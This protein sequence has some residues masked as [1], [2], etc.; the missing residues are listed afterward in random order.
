MISVDRGYVI[1]V[2]CITDGNRHVSTVVRLTVH[3]PRDLA[4]ICALDRNTVRRLCFGQ[5]PQSLAIHENAIDAPLWDI[6]G[7]ALSG[8][9]VIRRTYRVN[10]QGTYHMSPR[11]GRLNPCK[12]TSE[13]L[14][15]RAQHFRL[16]KLARFHKYFSMSPPGLLKKLW[17]YS[18]IAKMLGFLGLR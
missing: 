10:T 11:R 17:F 5:W 16:S 14:L 15:C 8:C 12:G 2:S 18:F 1:A 6:E 9:D 7:T 13:E 4:R 3:G